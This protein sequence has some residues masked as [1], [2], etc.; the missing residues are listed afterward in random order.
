MIF[1]SIFFSRF[2]YVL[3]VDSNIHCFFSILI[4]E[5]YQP[6]FCCWL[7]QYC[8]KWIENIDNCVYVVPWT[9]PRTYK[10]NQCWSLQRKKKFLFYKLKNTIFFLSS[11][12]LNIVIIRKF[13]S[14]FTV[15]F[16]VPNDW[17]VKLNDDDGEDYWLTVLTRY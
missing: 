1:F 8:M 14:F 4:I 10:Q 3:S 5:S 9:Q 13:L 11:S 16:S 17:I 7:E 15:F 12:S 6:F 2:F